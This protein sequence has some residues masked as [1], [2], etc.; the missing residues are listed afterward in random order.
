MFY[1]KICTCDLVV[2]QTTVWLSGTSASEEFK[3]HLT[4]PLA[5]KTLLLHH[6]ELGTLSSGQTLHLFSPFLKKQTTM[7]YLLITKS[8]FVTVCPSSEDETILSALSFTNPA[9]EFSEADDDDD[10]EVSNEVS[11]ALEDLDEDSSQCLTDSDD[12]EEWLPKKKSGQRQTRII[13]R[14]FSLQL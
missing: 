5:L 13:L 7:S 2:L 1:G 3:H 14:Y 9:N 8:S 11:L 12:L 6:R 4:E 10:D